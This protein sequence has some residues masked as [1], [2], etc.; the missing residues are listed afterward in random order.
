MSRR[1][2]L[3]SAVAIFGITLVVYAFMEDTVDVSQKDDSSYIPKASVV[4]VSVQTH[5]GVIRT[6]AEI[7]PRWAATLKAHVSGEV[8]AMSKN[9]MAGERIDKD[10]FLVQIEDSIYQARLAQANKSLADAELIHLQEQK[11]ANQAIRDWKRSG[12]NAELSD[13]AKNKPQ[14]EVA[15]QN[16]D[17]AKKNIVAAKQ[18]IAYT[19]ITAPFSG[20]VTERFVSIGQTVNAGDELLHI[21]AIENLEITASL[22]ARQWKNLAENWQGQ[23]AK[24]KDDHGQEIALAIMV[25]G[26]GFLDPATRQYKI[27]LEVSKSNKTRALA[28]E[29]VQVELPGRAVASSILIPESAF[30]REGFV[31]YVDHENRLRYFE[32]ET[33]FY[34]QNQLIVSVPKNNQLEKYHVIT[35][36]LASFIAGKEVQPVQVES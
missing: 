19:K 9:A 8:V 1:I 4:T 28:G 2:W 18:E 7:K 22:S 13:L 32:S 5:S 34:L 30:T 17:L 21:L 33:L 24:V 11:K 14:L 20:I 25:R 10:D 26:G 12:L 16:L 27:F 29:F 31:W 35:T 36:P 15:N 3:M 23:I 6:L